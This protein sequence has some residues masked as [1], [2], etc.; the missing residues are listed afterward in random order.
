MRQNNSR[1][2]YNDSDLYSEM[3]KV[4]SWLVIIIQKLIKDN[5]FCKINTR[6]IL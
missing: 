2:T 6:F 1:I 5:T 4:V 3:I